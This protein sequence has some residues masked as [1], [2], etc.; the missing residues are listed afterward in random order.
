MYYKESRKT[1][2]MKRKKNRI[3]KICT[4]VQYVYELYH[5]ES[6]LLFVHIQ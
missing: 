6:H 3:I 4:T 5:T 1:N 2:I